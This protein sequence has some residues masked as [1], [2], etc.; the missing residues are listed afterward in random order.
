MKRNKLVEK[1]YSNVTNFEELLDV[2]YGKSGTEVRDDFEYTA[3]LFI[4]AEKLKECRK[5]AKLTQEELALK[6]GTKKSYI[7]R[8]EKAKADIQI[9]TLFK[10]FEKGLGMNLAIKFS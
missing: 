4:I 7:S 9:S 10:I 3:Q 2:E 6:I 8:I 1:D 5:L